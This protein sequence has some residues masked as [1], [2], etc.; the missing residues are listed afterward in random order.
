MMMQSAE[1]RA[2]RAEGRGAK[3]PN[4]NQPVKVRSLWNLPSR[5]PQNND[6]TK[7]SQNVTICHDFLR[8][9]VEVEY[10][11]LARIFLSD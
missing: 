3:I 1:G 8:S 4:E 10:Q 2:Q 11:S 7:M 5:L 6:V 9:Q